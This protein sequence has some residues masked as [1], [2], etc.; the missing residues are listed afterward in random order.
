MCGCVVKEIQTL[1]N[2]DIDLDALRAACGPQTAG[3]MLTNPSTLGVF[4]RR[5]LAVARIVPRRRRAAVLRRCEPESDPGQG[6]P[7]RHGFRRH[8]HEPAQDFLHAH[9]GGGPGSGAVA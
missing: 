1:A 4:E 7:G 9:G 6:A 2:G 8:S 5:I 3:I